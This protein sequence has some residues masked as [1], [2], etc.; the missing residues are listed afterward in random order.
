ML[1]WHRRPFVI[2]SQPM[3]WECI[4][5]PGC[6]LLV[7][8]VWWVCLSSTL[9]WSL[10]FTD[11]DPVSGAVGETVTLTG[12]DIN[13]QIAYTVTIDGTAANFQRCYYDLHSPSRWLREPRRERW[14][15]RTGRKTLKS[16]FH[17]KSSE[18]SRAFSKFPRTSLFRDTR[19]PRGRTS[20]R[21]R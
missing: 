13:D 5:R 14:S 4:S 8:L 18:R 3:F 11:M 20:R 21:H 19:S 17:L 6:R 9:S 12:T 15:S 7:G 1:P 10:S 16:G 2:N